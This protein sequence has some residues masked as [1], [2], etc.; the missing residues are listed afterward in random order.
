MSQLRKVN[1]RNNATNTL[2]HKVAQIDDNQDV[3]LSEFLCL[4]FPSC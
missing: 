1:K 3:T 4:C 2:R